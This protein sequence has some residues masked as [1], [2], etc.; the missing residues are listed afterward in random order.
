MKF[1]NLSMNLHHCVTPISR[2]YETSSKSWEYYN[3]LFSNW[4]FL[5][6]KI[7]MHVLHKTIIGG[8]IVGVE[9]VEDQWVVNVCEGMA[10]CESWMVAMD[11]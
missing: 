3:C 4:N 6:A 8:K 11:V 10:K 1:N 2:W 9:V 5:K 7:R